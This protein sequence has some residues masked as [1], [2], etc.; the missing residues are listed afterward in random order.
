MKKRP[1]DINILHMCTVNDDHIWFLRYGARR[2]EFFVILDHVLFFR[3]S[4]NLKNQNFE[5]KNEKNTL[6]YCHFTHV[7]HKQQ[8]Y[9]IWFLR[10]E[11][12]L[13]V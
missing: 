7:Y 11:K 13:E 3:P 8:S 12:L 9:D 4:N 5:K 1:G 10:Y 6:R 2:K